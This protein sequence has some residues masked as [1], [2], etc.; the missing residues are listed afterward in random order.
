MK[1][2]FTLV[3]GILFLAAS[4]DRPEVI[5]TP[6]A[7]EGSVTFMAG[8][9]VFEMV[10]EDEGKFTVELYR[11]VT[12]DAL[13]VPVTITAGTAATG[14]F[15]ADKNSFDFAAG[16]NKA[17]IVF[18]YG[19]ITALAFGTQYK[20]N[21]KIDDPKQ[22]A[23]SGYD[24]V[25][26]VATRKLT[27]ITKGVG[28]YYSDFFEEDWDQPIV[29]LKEVNYYIW[30]ECWAAGTDIAFDVVAETPVLADVIATGYSDPTYGPVSMYL[31]NAVAAG[32]PAPQ[33]MEDGGD[34]LL[35]YY[36]QYRVAAGSFGISYE[37][38]ILPEGMTPATLTAK[39]L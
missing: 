19:D 39:A 26:V 24:E 20:I 7:G 32:A 35:L 12:T 11:G 21:I 17:S 28:K 16:A 23:I 37:Y 2:Y 15:V 27:K 30:P 13:S 4:C 34:M 33:F 14:I 29:F 9:A 1:K 38:F 18:T 31:N 3:L 22:V 8:D 5:Y 36:A 6:A 10:P 25:D